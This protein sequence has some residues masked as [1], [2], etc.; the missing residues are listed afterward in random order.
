MNTVGSNVPGQIHLVKL[1]VMSLR[2]HVDKTLEFT[3]RIKM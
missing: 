3:Y 2:Y 1:W